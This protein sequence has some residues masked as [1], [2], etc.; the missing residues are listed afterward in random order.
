MSTGYLQIFTLSASD[1]FPVDFVSITVTESN[2][3]VHSYQTDENGYSDPISLSAPDKDYSL[4]PDNT[5]V[6][7]YSVCT[8]VGTKTGWQDYTVTGVQIFDGQT[9][10]LTLAMTPTEMDVSRTAVASPE[11][12]DIEIPE[13]SLF[14]EENTG[15]GPAPAVYCDPQ[16][17]VLAEVVIPSR[18]TIHLAKPAVSGTNVT[19]TFRDY[20]KNVAS[21]EIY[22]TWPT[23]SLKAN[24]YAQISLALNRVYTEWYPSK[25]YSFNIT[26]S[27]SYDQYYVHGRSIFDSIS[28]QVDEIFNVYIRK[29]GTVN[30]FY[31]EYCDGKIVTS[32]PG[33]KQWGTK[34]LAE[35]GKTAL[36]IL[37][38]YYGN[39]IE[40][41]TSNNIAAI[42]QSY[43]GTPLKLGSTGTDVSIIQRQL[44]RITKNYPFFGT[45][46]VNGTFDSATESTVKKFQKQ[47]S[48]T[49]D[50]IVGKAT[51][52]KISYIYVAVKKLAE[53][54]SEGE[55][56]TGLPSTGTYPGTAIKEGDSGTSVKQIQF[57]LTVLAQFDPSIPSVTVD[58][59]FGPLT[60][61]SVKAF[62]TSVNLTPD[63]VVGQATW[64]AL[65]ADFMSVESDITLPGTT[66]IGEYPGTPLSVGSTGNEVRL[67]QFW[68]T[69][70]SDFYS[71]IPAVSTDG[72][73]GNATKAAVVAFQ[74]RF[75]L[76]AD[77]V[78]GPITWNK[79]YEVYADQTNGI[80]GTNGTPGT[81]PGTPLSVGSTGIY[82]KEMQYYLY[83]LGAYYP[84]IPII[85]Y[86][87]VFGTA[88]K[89][90]VIAYQKIAGLTADGIVGA[91]TWQSI[92]AAAL[93]LRETDG[94]TVRY[95][96][97]SPPAYTVKFGMSGNEVLY[98][99]YELQLASRFYDAIPDPGQ[100]GS[101]DETTENSVKAFQ[102]L[103]GLTV[104]GEVDTNTWNV[105]INS[106]KTLLDATAG[107]DY[108]PTGNYPGYVLGPDSTGPAVTELQT[109]INAIAARY[110]ALD[111]LNEDGWYGPQ[112]EDAVK[113]F[114]EG[115]GLPVT[116]V[117]DEVTWNTIVN[118][119]YEISGGTGRAS[120]GIKIFVYDQYENKMYTFNRALTDPMPYSTGTTL[121]VKEFRGSS[122]SNVLWTTTRAMESWNE[123]RR[124]YGSG[125]PVGYA[126]KRI[127]EGGHGTTSQHY[128]GVSFDVGQ[129]LSQTQRTRIWN[130]AKN[131]GVWG[132]VEPL[133]M[134]PTWVH[135]DRRYGTPA[136]G[137][138][139][140]YP[141]CRKGNRST[142]VLILQDA[143]NALGYSTKTLDGAFGSNTESALK[144]FQRNNSLS[145][146][147]V[148]GCNTWSK[149]A[150]A[151]VGIGRTP[152]V[153]D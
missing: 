86:D 67:V 92:Y 131:L 111:F 139:S 135:F 73:Y 98:I 117:V 148:C 71:T 152:T 119:Y 32:C 68:L 48:L 38:Y 13:H 3:T 124:T 137:G 44:N 127:W 138:T 37:K 145:A 61:A 65:Y 118:Y 56:A 107:E 121:S 140:G 141:T 40:L 108:I 29:T 52:Y 35:Q 109:Y 122:K 77:G 112:T 125:I 113:Q 79:L 144:A 17:F 93:R 69:V 94:P 27:T 85:S 9:A 30:P 82:V 97:D 63:G 96:L 26:N 31:A 64:K 83:L 80:L 4:D 43:P 132:Y 51:W 147:G 74:T 34:T 28:K 136:C 116:G 134:T 41:V 101:F 15:S 8:V 5:T 50:G 18:I 149:L 105:L 133:S 25:G 151:V 59:K 76:T 33:M 72:I 143:L 102:T 126:F 20:I 95:A 57:W 54:T 16:T 120:T 90:A 7:P 12:P 66:W 42:P 87:G 110:C 10:L 53:L 130:V 36:Q 2:G 146:D 153:I 142:Y 104:T 11:A 99:Q 106:T 129:T 91:L 19:V 49:Q 21:S 88:T 62:Q 6:L 84:A 70:L 123:T 45:L 55:E 58:G 128:A 114:Q 100:S 78:V 46:T 22:P 23:E 24:I 60:T 47:F 115:F 14:S 1:G 75:S 89:A 150:K 39:D 103:F 81:Y